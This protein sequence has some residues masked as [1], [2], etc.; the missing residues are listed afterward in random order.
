[1]SVQQDMKVGHRRPEGGPAR[2][3]DPRGVGRRA[4][5]A[6]GRGVSRTAAVYRVR[7][8]TARHEDGCRLR[9]AGYQNGRRVRAARYQDGHRIRAT[10][11]RWTRALRGSNGSWISSSI[12]NRARTIVPIA[13]SGL[14]KQRG[15]RRSGDE[16]SGL[17]H[18]RSHARG[19]LLGR[20][21]GLSPAAPRPEMGRLLDRV[22]AWTL[23]VRQSRRPA[24]ARQGVRIRRARRRRPDVPAD[25][26][27][28]PVGTADPPADSP[29]PSATRP[30]RSTMCSSAC[31]APAE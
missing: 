25:R 28:E 14:S 23:S 2:G 26:P 11:R 19:V 15:G 31:R 30:S 12:R 5:Q 17:P 20:R 3:R 18:H 24:S 4:I 6:G 10:R 29:T 7:V 16:S 1:M 13:G 9:A 21:C 22:G 8:R 27:A